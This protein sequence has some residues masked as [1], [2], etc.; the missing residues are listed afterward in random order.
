MLLLVVFTAQLHWLPSGGW[1]SAQQAVMPVLALSALPASYI[2]RVTRVSVIE[3]MEQAH[4]RTAIAKGLLPRTVILR[5][6][7]RSALIPVVTVSGPLAAV[8]VTGSFLVEELF[9]IPGVGRTFVTS[10]SQRDYGVIM[11]ITLFYTTVIIVAN[12]AVDVLY[13]VLDPR[14]RYASHG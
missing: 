11:G 4:V 14:I 10:L 5:H 9:A 7:L 6:V 8:L 2:A 13:A 3:A 12:F 1:G